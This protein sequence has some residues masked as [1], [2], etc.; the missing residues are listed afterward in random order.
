LVGVF[1]K[2][3]VKEKEKKYNFGKTSQQTKNNAKK[4]RRNHFE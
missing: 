1:E 2:L 3:S 4:K